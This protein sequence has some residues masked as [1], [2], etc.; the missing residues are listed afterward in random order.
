MES[1]DTLFSRKSYINC[2]GSLLDLSVPK[3]MGILNIT[4]DS[5]YDGGY[6]YDK[7]QAISQIDKMVEEGADII[8]VGSYSS[9]P[10][11]EDIPINEEWQ[12][13]YPVLELIR[14]RYPDIILSVDTFRAE[15]ANKSVSQYNVDIIND[16]SGGELDKDMFDVIS[17]LNV[18]YI[19]MHMKGTPQNMTTKAQ[20]EN[21]MKEIT[22]YFS[23]RIDRLRKMGMNDIIIDPGFGFSK[24]ID[25]NYMLLK[26]LKDLDIIGLPILVGVSRKSMIYKYLH[27]EPHE[28][29]NGTTV[30]NTL[31]LLQ[32]TNILRVHDV[33]E[34]RQVVDLITKYNHA[35]WLD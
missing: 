29:L 16:I 2:Q 25:Q 23:S 26:N 1:K 21:M 33:K 9:R 14:E 24:N 35:A 30:L 11:A 27:I 4:P 15:I 17:E 12:R 28:A 5:F 7:D 31:A 6:Y 10:G 13:L 18:P 20:Y 32:G 8:D 34:A 22:D 19:M 3:V